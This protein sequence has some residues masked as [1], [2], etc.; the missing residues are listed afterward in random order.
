MMRLI[1]GP[2]NHRIIHD[3]GTVNQKMSIYSE[4]TGKDRKTPKIGCK[5]GYAIYE[6]NE[7]RTQSFWL[8]NVWDGTHEGFYDGNHFNFGE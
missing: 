7:E 3:N 5:S 2:W 6:P 1:G 4:F 8:G